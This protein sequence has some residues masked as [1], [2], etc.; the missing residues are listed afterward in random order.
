MKKFLIFDT[1]KDVSC[2]NSSFESEKFSFSKFTTE[3][4][5]IVQNPQHVALHKGLHGSIQNKKK[6]FKF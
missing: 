2:K 6:V 4:S 5:Q 3:F 1:P